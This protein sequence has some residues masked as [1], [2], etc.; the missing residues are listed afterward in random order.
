MVTKTPAKTISPEEYLAQEEQATE[1]HEYIQGKIKLISGG[2]P[3][4]SKISF[5]T[6]IAFRFALKKQPYE[7]FHVDQR[8]W[9]PSQQIF[10]Y[11]DVMITAK[12]LVMLEGRK[13]TVMNA[14]LAAE[15]LSPSTRNYD[16]GDK[17]QYYRSI[18]EFQDYLLI[19]QDRISVE[20]YSQIE[21]QKWSLTEYTNIEDA[22]QFESLGCDIALADIY[23][24]IEL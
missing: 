11:P 8:L 5:S 12:P 2:T 22:I 7:V 13:D 24:D 18:P 20:H 3:Q 21:T 9:I 4:H 23:E 15:V 6:V 1:R 14:Y 17:F 16:R 19:E 10:T